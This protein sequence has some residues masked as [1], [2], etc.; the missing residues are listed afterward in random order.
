MPE[1]IIE[2]YTGPQIATNTNTPVPGP[3]GNAGWSPAGFAVVTDGN[4]R[5]LQITDWVGG[6]GT[7]PSVVNQFLGAT[8]IVSTAAAA[9]D[10][11]GL[12]G[13]QG[14]PGTAGTTLPSYTG[15]DNKVLGLLA[16][17]LAWVAQAGGSS[18]PSF[19]GNDGKVLGLVAGALSWVTQAVG[20]ALPTVATAD[21]GKVLTVVSGAWAA[22]ASTNPSTLARFIAL[23]ETPYNATSNATGYNGVTVQFEVPTVNS[24]PANWNATTKKYTISASGM[25]RLDLALNMYNLHNAPLTAQRI[26]IEFQRAGFAASTIEFGGTQQ[27]DPGQGKFYYGAI[28]LYLKAGDVIF[29]NWANELSSVP[30]RI[31]SITSGTSIERTNYFGVNQIA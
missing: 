20:A 19:T 2:V 13:L 4:R 30:V 11:R 26:Y 7:K 3:Q 9:V 28:D 6:A 31:G 10:V 22:A 12:Q 18:L 8:G 14:N 17:A 23:L 15:N 24:I 16:G 5:V 27:L 21:N 25:Y 29:P 1:T